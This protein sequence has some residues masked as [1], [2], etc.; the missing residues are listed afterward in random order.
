MGSRGEERVVELREL[1]DKRDKGELA[2]PR[3]R[4]EWGLGGEGRQ[5]GT[6]KQFWFH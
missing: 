2:L 3:D 1:R 4:R 6:R 5:R